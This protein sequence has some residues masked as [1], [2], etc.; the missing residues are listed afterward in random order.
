MTKK[1]IVILSV[2]RT[3]SSVLRALLDQT[4][5]D[6]FIQGENFLCS[7]W[8]YRYHSALHRQIMRPSREFD[9]Y[10]DERSPFFARV[11]PEEVQEEL[12][13]LT[14]RSITRG[15][16][17]RV[18]G[19]KEIRWHDYSGG[20]IDDVADYFRFLSLYMPDV[21]LLLSTREPTELA[22]SGWWKEDGTTSGEIARR[23]D[24]LLQLCNMGLR[25]FVVPHA[26]IKANNLGAMFDFLGEPFR[27]AEVARVL[28][29]RHSF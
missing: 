16:A 27:E 9:S 11:R 20:N 14:V 25:A 24:W 28:A 4:L 21:R 13:Q 7:W 3:G 19:F 18:H 17:A 29:T 12:R 15:R 10:T 5:D 1:T 26:D 23:Q 8:L 2:G 22:S 6:A